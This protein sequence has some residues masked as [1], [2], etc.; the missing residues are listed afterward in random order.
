MRGLTKME[1]RV[2]EAIQAAIPSPRV[3][4]TVDGVEISSHEIGIA[5]AECLLIARAAIRA[6]REP[7]DQQ[8]E[9]LSATDKLWRELDSKTVWQ[10]YIDAASPPETPSA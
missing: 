2:A 6:M 8:Y 3:R 7:T 4:F 9:S 1:V 10:T 5:W